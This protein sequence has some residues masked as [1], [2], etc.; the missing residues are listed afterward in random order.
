M[1]HRVPL[2][3]LALVS[4]LLLVSACS[5]KE[6]PEAAKAPAEIGVIVGIIVGVVGLLL[7][8]YW[9]WRKDRR[10]ERALTAWLENEAG[11]ETVL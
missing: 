5:K 11:G 2:K 3:T 7:G 10:E 4:V 1:S 6:A 9:Q 8:Q